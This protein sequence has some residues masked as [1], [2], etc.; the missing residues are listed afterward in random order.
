MRRAW[1]VVGG[2]AVVV[3]LVGGTYTA[4]NL[5]A[6]DEITRTSTV[7]AAGLRAV[8]VD[9]DNGRV[10]VVGTDADEVRVVADI[11]SGLRRTRS[12]V[13]VR[14]GTLLVRGDCPRGW[15]IR[16]RVDYR[17]E[18]PRRLGV[19]VDNGNGRLALEGVD[20]DVTVDN[21]NGRVEVARLRGALR[22]RTSN[23]SVTATALASA[24]VSAE[25]QNGRVHLAFDAAPRVVQAVTQ[26]GGV[27]VVV[28]QDE[29]GYRVDVDTANGATD[30]SVRTDPASERSIVAET[31]N[32]SVVV[33][34]PATSG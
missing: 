7:D 34:Y 25:S 9:S 20:G 6:H 24:D 4:V 27:E 8:A 15:T 28:P 22:V 32:G 26:N 1:R 10:D 29:V 13:L 17:L 21:S 30:T 14:D 18:V 31:R 11:S 3:A 2:L 16:C 12:D 33:R 23:G 19:Q 5:L